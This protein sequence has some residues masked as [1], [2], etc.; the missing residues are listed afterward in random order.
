MLALVLVA[1]I[2]AWLLWP[3]DE[4]PGDA[5][6]STTESSASS[7]PSASEDPTSETPSETPTETPSETATE[8]EEPTTEPS[9]SD[10]AAGT[11]AAMRA[12]VQDYF[13]RVTSDPESTFQLLTPEFQAA[14]GGIDG[15]TGFWSTIES[16]TPRAIRADPR[17]LTTSYTIDYVTT[18][19]RATTQ[20]GRLQLEQQGDGF[21]IAG[22][23]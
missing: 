3:R 22:E 4:E 19:G 11:P 2:G 18:A 16:A 12:F 20:Q 7:E 9:P 17:T 14:S 21:L 10:P 15:Y 13:A 5:G 23:G 1:G 6:G 8:S